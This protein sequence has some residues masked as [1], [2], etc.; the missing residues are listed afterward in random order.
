MLS[1]SHRG[2]VSAC[3]DLTLGKLSVV[4]YPCRGQAALTTAMPVIAFAAASASGAFLLNWVDATFGA[5][6]A[7]LAL[8]VTV[9]DLDR[10]EIPDMASLII[11]LLGLAWTLRASGFYASAL[12]EAFTRSLLCGALF[13]AVRALYQAIRGIEGLGLGDVKLAGAGAP[14]LSWSHTVFALTLAVGAAITLVIVKALL[15]RERIRART[16]IPFGAFLA[17]AIW[18]TWLAQVRGI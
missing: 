1:A 10:F 5:L 2:F 12:I 3:R 9:V 13:L 17:P 15:T 4:N 6:L 8:V 7:G 18:V 11:F 16:A 14:W